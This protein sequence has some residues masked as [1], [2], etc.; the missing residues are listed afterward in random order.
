MAF[1]LLFLQNSIRLQAVFC[2][3]VVLFFLSTPNTFAQDTPANSLRPTPADTT[4]QSSPPRADSLAIQIASTSTDTSKQVAALDT[5]KPLPRPS[6]VALAL[7]KDESNYIK[8]VYGQPFKKGRIVFG[9]LEKWGQVWRA[10]ANEATEITFTRDVKID[11]KVLRTGTYTLFM[12]PNPDKWTV[13]LN[14]ELGQWGTYNYKPEKD[15]MR[16]NVSARKNEQIFEALTYKFNET[17]AGAE[18][19]LMWD[20]VKVNIPIQ[21]S[22]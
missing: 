18:L 12:I 20:D 16:F 22:R 1:F 2:G 7:F 8:L 19:S 21:F 17:D 11:G 5:V 15:I 4:V 14:A 3:A 13:I 6:P 10:G 9:N